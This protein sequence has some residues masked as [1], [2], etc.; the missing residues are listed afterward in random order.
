MYTWIDYIEFLLPSTQFNLSGQILKTN[1]PVSLFTINNLHILHSDLILK[2]R[3]Q[4]HI[5]S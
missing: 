1:L 4:G 3:G 2:Q 5:I